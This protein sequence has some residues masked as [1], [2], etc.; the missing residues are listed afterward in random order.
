MPPRSPRPRRPAV[1]TRRGR[2][3]ACRRSAARC[4]STWTS[5]LQAATDARWTNSCGVTPVD[6]RSAFSAAISRAS[7]ATNPRAVPR[8]VRALA[9]RVEHD[10]V[11]QVAELQA[12][13]RRSVVEPQLAV[14]LVQ[15]QQDVV[16]RARSA[17]S[18]EE[19]ERRGGAGRV[20]RVVEPQDARPLPGAPRRSR[21]GRAGSR[22][23]R[24]ASRTASPPA[25]RAPRSGIVYPGAV[26]STR[27]RPDRG[28]QDGLRQREDRLLAA[29]RGD[30]VG[31]RIERRR[32][33]AG[34]PTP[35]S[36]RA[37]PADRP[38]AGTTTWER[39]PRAAASRMNAGV[40]SRGS[41][42]PRSIKARPASS[43]SC[44]RRSS[45]SNGYGSTF[46]IPGD[47]SI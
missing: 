42:T 37:A 12:R 36:R 17:A 5:S 21:R 22:A 27:S 44:L 2:A 13:G 33:T 11:R 46:R 25:N 24:A 29:E 35:R 26:T 47:S 19:R 30:Q 45:S 3:R 10:D 23:P 43:A 40:S 7:P 15:R 34:R 4:S 41:P 6:G 20:V 1:G 14:R 28:I 32:R 16:R 18:L 31:R 8:H 38:R 9:Q 39:W